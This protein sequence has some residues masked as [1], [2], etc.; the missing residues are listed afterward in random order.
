MTDS[1]ASTVLW[2]RLLYMLTPQL[3]I[4]ENLRKVVQGK[5]VLEVGFG[6]G[7]G[8]LQYAA[9]AEYVDAI[10]LDA[11]AVSFA[12]RIIPL[13]NVRW[14]HDDFTN[15]SH[16]Y[17]GYDLVVMIEVLE[18]IEA[19]AKALKNVYAA[20]APGAACIITAPNSLRYRKRAEA[21]NVREWTPGE[22][23][24]GLS[25]YFPKVW[26]LDA[27]LSP[28]VTDGESRETPIIAGAHRVR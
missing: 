18:H 3:D 2:R 5:K 28:M 9:L 1:Q 16:T 11:A 10:E 25:T 8:T 4:Y 6:T 27:T 24:A 20:L 19:T 12:R 17:R 15:P 22:F 26:L 14:L 21:L 23:K 13:R 7:F